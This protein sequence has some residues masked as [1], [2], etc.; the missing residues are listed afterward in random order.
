MYICFFFFFSSKRRHTR[1]LGDWSS[2]VCS[3]DLGLAFGDTASF[4]PRKPWFSCS[5]AR[6]SKDLYATSSTTP[7]A[8]AGSAYGHQSWTG[9]RRLRGKSS[10]GRPV[11]Q[12]DLG[13][14]SPRKLL[15][16]VSSLDCS[17]GSPALS[18]ERMLAQGRASLAPPIEQ[19]ANR[20]DVLPVEF[21]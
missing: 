3:S 1:S 5:K 19:C 9:L 21:S 8:P 14:R 4:S 10:T 20:P 6:G 11:R 16:A 7:P 18:G 13:Q 17:G 12:S 15:R 2:D